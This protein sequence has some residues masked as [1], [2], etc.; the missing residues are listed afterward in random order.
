[1]GKEKDERGLVR[2]VCWRLWDV[3]DSCSR[4]PVCEVWGGI[5]KQQG[6]GEN[7]GK[8]IE[9]VDEVDESISDV[10]SKIADGCTLPRTRSDG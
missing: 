5:F 10:W 2:A 4:I 7:D 1:M 6:E 8:D 3:Q 9:V